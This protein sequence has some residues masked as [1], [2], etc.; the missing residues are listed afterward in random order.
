MTIPSAPLQSKHPRYTGENLEKNKVLYT[1]LEMLST[2][3]GCS[4]AQLALA[5]VLHQGDDV[6]PIPGRV[7]NISML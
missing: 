7:F 2:K 4:A 5:W 6:V 1:G 3:Y